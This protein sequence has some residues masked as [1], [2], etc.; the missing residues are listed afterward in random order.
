VDVFAFG[1]RDPKPIYAGEGASVVMDLANGA[2]ARLS[3]EGTWYAGRCR[4][5]TCGRLGMYFRECM[6][7]RVVRVALQHERGASF[8]ST[9]SK[10]V[11][12]SSKNN[13]ESD[14]RT[15]VARG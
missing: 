4:V 13:V 14:L 9:R 12:I 2:S 11:I 1:E 8:E 6:S 7:E 5:D 15:F 3:R 10:N